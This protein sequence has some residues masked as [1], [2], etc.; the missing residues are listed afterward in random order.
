M[1]LYVDNEKEIMVSSNFREVFFGNEC[2]EIELE[3][4]QALIYVHYSTIRNPDEIFA[5]GFRE[6]HPYAVLNRIDGL[7][8]YKVLQQFAAISTQIYLSSRF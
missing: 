7:I 2:Y 5:G 8:K 4:V 3:A 1:P 6:D